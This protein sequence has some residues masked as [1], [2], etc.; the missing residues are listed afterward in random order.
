MGEEHSKAVQCHFVDF[1]CCLLSTLWGV[2][3][4]ARAMNL[5]HTD[6]TADQAGLPNVYIVHPRGLSQ[7]VKQ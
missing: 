5:L 1:P 2:A 6:A 4:S 7:S 3:M